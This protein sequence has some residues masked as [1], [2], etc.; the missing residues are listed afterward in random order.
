MTI[1]LMG[2]VTA[3]TEGDVTV[4]DLSHLPAAKVKMLY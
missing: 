1:F 3:V 2:D 4:I